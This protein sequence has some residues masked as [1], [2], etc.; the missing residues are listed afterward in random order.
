MVSRELAR[1]ARQFADQQSERLADLPT[2]RH[3]VV[4]VTAVS[5]ATVTVTWRTKTLTG[6]ALAS[7]TPAAGDRV[8]CVLVD[9][10]LIVIDRIP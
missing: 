6:T 4:D 9:N 5:G 2:V 10:Q 7:Y 3:L 8:L 1:A